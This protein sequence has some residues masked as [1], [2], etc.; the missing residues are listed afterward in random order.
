MSQAR[1]KNTNLIHRAEITRPRRRRCSGL[2]V[3]KVASA[4]VKAEAVGHRLGKV[5][6][7]PGCMGERSAG[8]GLQRIQEKRKGVKFIQNSAAN[9]RLLAVQLPNTFRQAARTSLHPPP[10]TFPGPCS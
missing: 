6:A 2:A 3:A 1:V 4:V 10:V 5:S 9:H 7:T 8:L